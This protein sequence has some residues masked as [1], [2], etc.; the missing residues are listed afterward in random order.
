MQTLALLVAEISAPALLLSGSGLVAHNPAAEQLCEAAGLSPREFARRGRAALVGDSRTQGSGRNGR[1]LWRLGPHTLTLRWRALPADP[2]LRLLLIDRV[3]PPLAAS[4]SGHAGAVP[5]ARLKPLAL[6]EPPS[7]RRRRTDR[8]GGQSGQA[9]ALGGAPIQRPE[10]AVDAFVSAC[11]SAHMKRLES[12]TRAGSYRVDTGS[13]RLS[14]SPLAREL[15]GLEAREE[16]GF[17]DLLARFDEP[18]AQ[19][20]NAFHREVLNGTDI[21]S[22]EVELPRGEAAPLTLELRLRGE[23][24]DD[25]ARHL[26][27]AVLDITERAQNEQRVRFLAYHDALTRLPNRALFMEKSAQFIRRAKER[28]ETLALHL[29]DLDGFKQ[30]NDS[31]GHLA[32]DRVLQV[33]AQRIVGNVRGDDMVFRLGGDEFAVLHLGVQTAENVAKLGA[34]LVRVLGEPIDIGDERVAVGAS[35]GGALYKQ[36]DSIQHLLLRADEALYEIK[37]RGKGNFKLAA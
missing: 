6:V 35:I 8:D 12:L 2:A 23:A 9:P 37:R 11:E 13:G 25:G 28:G 29:V 14:L 31:L 7:E 24:D 36:E 10:P 5:T 27:A 16:L 26:Y 22:I 17:A 19:R 15:L 4:S 33:S 21:T 18:Q 3:E 20:V 30:I 32:G 1:L 34:R